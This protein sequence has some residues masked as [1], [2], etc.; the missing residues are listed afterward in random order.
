M[1]S[2]IDCGFFIFDFSTKAPL[3]IQPFE[4][5]DDFLLDIDK[6]NY[7]IVLMTN[8]IGEA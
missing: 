3:V 8:I 7:R 4:N 2:W 5:D 1:D 6:L